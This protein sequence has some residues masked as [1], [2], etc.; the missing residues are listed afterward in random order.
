[1]KAKVL[2][3]LLGSLVAGVAMADVST[4]LTV[5][6][7]GPGGHSNGAYGRTN[8]VHAASRAIL[9]IEKAIPSTKECVVSNFNG[10]NSVNSIASDGHF[11]VSL[12]AKNAKALEA[13]KAKVQTAV[14]KGVEAENQ[15]RGVKPGD[16]T[17]GVPAAISFT[18]R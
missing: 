4:V 1:M 6:L 5:D 16:L 12:K 3:A 7:L 14:Q 10:G 17:G 18:I 11:T 2:V 9:E 13:L 8:A 15:F